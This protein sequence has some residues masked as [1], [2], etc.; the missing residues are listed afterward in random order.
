MSATIRAD[1]IV[2]G[3]GIAG[4]GVAAH[5]AEEMSVILLE[6]ESFPGYHSTGR[7]AALFSQVYGGPVVRA[8]SQASRAFLFDP[9]AGFADAPLT[10]ERGFLCIAGEEQLGALIARAG[11][12]DVSSIVTAITAADALARCPILKPNVVRGAWV[13]VG[14]H[15]IDVDLLHQGYLR[16]LRARR[17]R[18]LTDHEV[19]ALKHA[20]GNWLVEAGDAKFEALVVVNAAGAWADDVAAL[21]GA[22]KI[23]LAPKRR[24]AVLVD[25][26]VGMDVSNWPLVM[27][28]EEQFYFKPDAGRLLLSA[29]DEAPSEPCDAQAEQIDVA[30][31]IDRVQQF[32]N[33]D[34]KRVVRSWAGL[35]SFVRDRSPVAGFDAKVPGF[36]W[37]AGQ[38]G[39][40]IQTAPALSR[41]AAALV[42]GRPLPVDITTLGLTEATLSPA[43]LA[44]LESGRVHSV[45][46]SN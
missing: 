17:G 5:L 19:V 41:I 28:V 18:V 3:A 6:R 33:L 38:G 40:G 26:P 20:G 22:S 37:L 29:A 46:E 9:P 30:I 32:A 1:V 2:I 43:R 45:A 39:Y 11:E 36:F 16:L 27:D 14:A 35:R 34:V 25:G 10:R 31:A 4:A 12:A 23:G 21:A 24:T 8:L 42:H 44:P 15:D 13:E 7:S